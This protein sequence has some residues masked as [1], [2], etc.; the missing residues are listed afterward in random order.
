MTRRR[1]LPPT[2]PAAEAYRALRVLLDNTPSI[3]AAEEIGRA[4]T[5]QAAQQLARADTP[6]LVWSET[7]PGHWIAVRPTVGYVVEATPTPAERIQ[8]GGYHRREG[9]WPQPR[10][11][12]G[13][14]PAAAA[15][16]PDA[17]DDD[18]QGEDD[19]ADGDEAAEV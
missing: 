19:E 16:L 17:D 4:A 2:V 10:L 12:G 14:G 13:N 11:V 5:L 18:D 3:K 15:T 7:M 8:P 9:P 1:V 6:P